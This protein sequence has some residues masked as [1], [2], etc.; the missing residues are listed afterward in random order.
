MKTNSY[1]T[2][3]TSLRG[4]AALLTVVYHVD[5]ML[6]NGGGLLLRTADSLMFSR[7][8]LMVDF[9][10]ILSGFIMLHV[11]GTSFS[12]GVTSA[13]F[14]KFTLARFA[15][16][17]PLHLA[18]LLYCVALYAIA[19]RLGVPE[20]PIAQAANSPA[21]LVSN[22][23]LLQSMNVHEWFTWV[24]A[25]WSIST[26]WWMYMLFPFL[27]VPFARIGAAGRA[28]VVAL[29]FAGYVGI[30]LWIVP[31]VTVPASIP[32][33]KLDPASLSLDVAYQYGILRCLFGFLIGMALYR[34]YQQS[35]GKRWLG[36][37][38]AML[39]LVACEMLA[40]HVA[41][42]DALTVTFLPLILLSAAYGS[43]RMDQLLG[44]TP[45]RTLGDWSFSIYLTHQP[46][47]FTWFAYVGYR[48]LGTPPV[49]A[50]SPPPV[51][52][53]LAGWGQC[54]LFIALLL[55][56][57]RLTYRYIELPAR[58]HINAWARPVA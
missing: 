50:S 3:L 22:L 11:Y 51:T 2:N 57:A 5:L 36:N 42:P 55:V 25:S 7:L 43:Q 58:Q 21:S 20:N 45:M 32:F 49:A 37:G 46:M 41:A 27:V 4:I 47:L 29:C 39:A 14:R 30:M 53:L 23:L 34:A 24:H 35:W 40:L 56:V 52:S 18:T 8:Y 38:Y 31:I 6:G 10:F 15:R 54:G 13:A 16:V 26:E 33:A 1:L 9:F 44:S 12:R 19:A 17:Y 28:V 48:A